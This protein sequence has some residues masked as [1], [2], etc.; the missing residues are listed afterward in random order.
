MW[1][2]YAL[3]PLLLMFV[4]LVLLITFLVH[5]LNL[6]QQIW[7]KCEIL[8]FFITF[9]IK[10]KKKKKKKIRSYWCF[11]QTLKPNAQKTAPKTKKHIK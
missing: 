6:F 8:R 9:L 2:K 5:F 1:R 7:K 3:F 10:K 4:K 11:F